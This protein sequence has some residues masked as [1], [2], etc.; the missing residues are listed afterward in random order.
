M[1]SVTTRIS[2]RKEEP[3]HHSIGNGVVTSSRDS[4]VAPSAALSDAGSDGSEPSSQNSNP[5]SGSS[6]H[7]DLNPPVVADPTA[8]NGKGEVIVVKVGTSTIMRGE[9]EEG[10]IALSTLALLVDTLVALRKAGFHV[11]LVTS[12]AVG[13]GCK[14]LGLKKKPESLA[15][16]QA[17]AAI[18]QSSLMRTYEELFGYANQHVAQ[19]LLARGDVAKS[20]QYFNARNTL[21]ELLRLGVIPIVNENDTIATEE[22]RFGDN[23]RLSA[24]V[25]GLLDAKWL[26]LLTDVDQ[27]YT[28]DPRTDPSAAPIDVVEDIESLMVNTGGD[29]KGGTQW[30]TGGMGT[31]VTAARLATAAEVT[32]CI[33]NGAKPEN[34]LNFV[35]PNKVKA[36]GTVFLPQKK[37]IRGGRKRW[38]AHGLK[39]SGTIYVDDGAEKAILRKKSLFAAGITKVEGDFDAEAC[40]HVCNSRGEEIAR[41]LVNYSSDEIEKVRGLHSEILLEVLGYEGPEEIIHR[42]NLVDVPSG[43]ND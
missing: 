15:G 38:I 32:V 13:L 29:G 36:I 16:R 26:F 14:R 3:E 17:M 35:L 1:S 31:K 6:S 34:I 18:G 9:E 25:A 7:V 33:M 10:D 30:G 27:M 12:G 8:N 39:P 41:G 43:C 19:I 42:H 20:H 24:M 23:D 28:A 4:S 2:H 37:V 11:V 22:L 40:V 21:F 5:L